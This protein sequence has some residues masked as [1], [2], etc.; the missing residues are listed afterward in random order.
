ML[1]GLQTKCSL[2]NCRSRLDR[3]LRDAES[4]STGLRRSKERLQRAEADLKTPCL[5]PRLQ[6]TGEST[7]GRCPSPLSR[8]CQGC[9][10][11]S[12]LS[13]F[14]GKRVPF[15]LFSYQSLLEKCFYVDAASPPALL[16][17]LRSSLSPRCA[18]ALHQRDPSFCSQASSGSALGLTSQSELVSLLP[19]SR[20]EPSP[21]TFLCQSSL[22]NKG[23]RCLRP[24]GSFPPSA[25]LLL[26]LWRERGVPL[27][28][29]PLRHYGNHRKHV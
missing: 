10:G 18:W 1:F 24:A 22:E 14:F 28:L 9:Q 6:L 12:L 20:T 25:L 3:H 7:W 26:L 23:R 11:L 15:V 2:G 29:R 21:L 17:G 4:N 27:R 16:S 8:G 13:S 19:S 5:S